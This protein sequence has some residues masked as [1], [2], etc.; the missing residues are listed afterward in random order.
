VG[1]SALFAVFLV[2]G[3]DVVRSRLRKLSPWIAA[4]FVSLAVVVLL[5]HGGK[6]WARSSAQVE[7][8]TFK[9]AAQR[10]WALDAD[11]PDATI[12]QKRVVIVTGGDFT[13]IA[14]LPWVRL[15]HGHPL[16]RSYTRLSGALWVHEIT[17]T[18]PNVIEL[19]VFSNELEDT[20]VGSLYRSKTAGFRPGD[21]VT[22][23]GMRVEVLR[24]EGPHPWRTRITFEPSLDDPSYLF[25]H[26][27]PDGI[28]PFTMPP[29][30]EKLQLAPPARPRL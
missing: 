25:L 18:A 5:V 14:N 20:M 27:M 10:R 7:G 13:T 23:P 1:A 17:R 15:A 9:V 16:P 26:S 3:Y 4:A 8:L 22:I 29:V 12:A 30:G 19:A 11:I 28:R 24:T 6:A 2:T 21:V